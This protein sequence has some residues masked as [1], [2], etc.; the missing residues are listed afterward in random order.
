MDYQK[1]QM[2]IQVHIL[3]VHQQLPEVISTKLYKTLGLIEFVNLSASDSPNQM[4]M[5]MINPGTCNARGPIFNTG[6]I[7]GYPP[8]ARLCVC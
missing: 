6:S 7:M 8:T 5:I 4:P 2:E 3:Y 1:K